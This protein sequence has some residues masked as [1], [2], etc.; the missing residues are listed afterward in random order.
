MDKLCPVHS[1]LVFD[2]RDIRTDIKSI[3]KDQVRN[4]ML[5]IFLSGTSAFGGSWIGSKMFDDDEGVRS[6]TFDVN[7]DREFGECEM[8]AGFDAG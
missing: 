1:E 3:M 2:I 7:A 8:D 5:I 6:D 4:R